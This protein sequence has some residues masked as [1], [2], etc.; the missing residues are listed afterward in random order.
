MTIVEDREALD[1]VCSQLQQLESTWFVC[2]KDFEKHTTNNDI[3][4]IVI[5]IEEEVYVIGIDH[6]DLMCFNKE[7]IHD[8]ITAPQ[9]KKVFHK[10][11]V[12]HS[13]NLNGHIQDIE[14]HHYLKRGKPLLLDEK[15]EGYKS[16]MFSRNIYDDLASSLPIMKLVDTITEIIKEY[17]DISEDLEGYDWF[18]DKFIPT[19]AKIESRGLSADTKTF[20]EILNGKAKHIHNGKVYT[21]YNPFTSTG[22]PSNRHGGVNYAALN[23]K[24]GSRGVFQ[25]KENMYVQLD[26]DAYHPRI[27]GNMI[28]YD[29]PM[30]S[31]HEWLAE[32]YDVSY[33]ESKGIT[34]RQIYGGIENQYKDIEFLG[35]IDKFIQSHWEVVLEDGYVSTYYRRIYLDWIDNVNPLKA[36]NYLL[37][38]IETERNID[39]LYEILKLIDGTDVHVILYIYDAILFETPKDV[40]KELMKQI[41]R[42]L[43][44]G[45]FPVSYSYGTTFQDL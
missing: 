15:F 11:R 36:F 9:P 42:I 14:T 28:E 33:E 23:K 39:R 32:R 22:R 27:I 6:V 21:E 34:F 17:E 1:R 3:S 12:I 5:K 19:L 8:L 38:A 25:S 45:G 10:K 4:F 20:K 35:E 18:N 30:K 16:Y 7:D 44:K 24:D 29:L 2:W 40:D 37:Q 43:T 26:F 41:K 13:L 31:V